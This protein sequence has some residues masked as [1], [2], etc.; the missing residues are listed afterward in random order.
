MAEFIQDQVLAISQGEAAY[1]LR[2]AWNR[3]YGEYP[4]I[5][6]LA[7]LWAQWA[8]ETGR[9]KAIH[10][11]NF[12]NIK[13]VAN[14]PCDWTYYRCNE[15]IGGKVVWFDPPHPASCFRAY[16]TSVDGA[17]DY[18]CFLAKKARYA[19][20][21]QQVIAGNPSAFSHE[22][23]VAGYYTADEGLYTRGVVSL[24]NEF[25]KKA[26]ELLAWRPED[27]VCMGPNCE[28]QLHDLFTDAEKQQILNL[29]AQLAMQSIDEYFAMTD[30][31]PE[32]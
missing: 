3:L 1:A 4:S 16:R 17:Y 20:A 30:R 11:F 12:G 14:G 26:D 18:I 32:D 31:N 13:A 5:A 10:C 25:K 7:L 22:L 29:G 23:K 2:E 28:E 6:S 15:I 27:A 19:K 24:C 8:L 21:W 9:G